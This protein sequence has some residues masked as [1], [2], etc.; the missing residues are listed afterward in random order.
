MA[1][2]SFVENIKSK[3][4]AALSPERLEIRDDSG[5]HKGHAGAPADG[6][7]HYHVMIVSAAFEGLALPARHRLVY[8]ALADEMRQHIHALSLE[9]LTLQ[10]YNHK[11]N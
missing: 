4:S 10:E 1:D 8:T 11:Y 2:N 3:L 5:R 6:N 7:S 9:T